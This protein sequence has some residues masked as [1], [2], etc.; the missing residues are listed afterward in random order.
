MSLREGKK[1]FVDPF[2]QRR[3]DEAAMKEKIQQAQN[4]AAVENA[5]SGNVPP[6]NLGT[7]TKSDAE[8]KKELE[9]FR[10]VTEKDIEIAQQLIFRGYA[11]K[12]I[13]HSMLGIKIKIT[14]LSSEELSLIDNI[15][16]QMLK[17][18]KD[19]GQEES[20][21]DFEVYN[22]KSALN[23]SLSY[24]GVSKINDEIMDFDK[25][26]S[27]EKIKHSIKVLSD[28]E[29]ENGIGKEYFE[30][31][32]D[33]KNSIKKRCLTFKNAVHSHLKNFIIVERSNFDSDI[34]AIMSKK[35]I[36]PKS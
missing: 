17:Q 1:P 13:E 12:I 15:T 9:E 3:L 2:E 25:E 19:L 31:K 24:V 8:T 14:T 32:E 7:N 16:L 6:P 4:E 28:F 10:Q 11:E 35:A 5:I 26:Y 20:L 21:T 33:V 18:Y 30:K 34:D 22:Y 23:I 36:I 29:V 27:L